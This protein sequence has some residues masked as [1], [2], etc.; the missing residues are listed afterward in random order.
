MR[1]FIALVIVTLLASCADVLG[2]GDF[3]GQ[4]AS[5]DGTTEA[6]A[7]DAAPD[8]GMDEAEAGCVSATADA[9]AGIFVSP[10]GSTDATTCGTETVPCA[11]V[12]TGLDRAHVITGKSIVYV[13]RGTYQESIVLYPG[14]RLEGGWDVLDN[15]TSNSWVQ[16]CSAA[17]SAVVI[18]PQTQNVTVAA[19]DLGGSV[20]V[21]TLTIASKPMAANGESLYGLF[22][23]GASTTLTLTNVN[24]TVAAGGDG[25]T[26]AD[27]PPGDAGGSGC[28]AED[29]A[30]GVVGSL[31]LGADAG[32]FDPDGWE[33]Q[34]GTPG[35]VGTGGAGGATGSTGACSACGSCQNF[36]GCSFKTN[37]TNSCGA[38]GLPGCGGDPGSA[39]NP[40]GGAGSSIGVYV[41]DATV[42]LEG[43]S[44]QVARGGN[45][46][47]GG[48]GGLG[49][50]GG[51]GVV[52]EAGAACSTSCNGS[53][54]PVSGNGPGGAA[55]GSGG[56]GGQGGAGGG[57]AGGCS[58]ATFQGGTG[59][60]LATMTT[61]AHGEAGLGGGPD[62]AA[63]AIGVAG[64]HFP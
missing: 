53:C 49:G 11:S 48:S 58:Y 2:L 7:P 4:D 35:S 17:S 1:R 63:G 42:M 27:G 30:A 62:S 57:G 47:S 22:A 24:V 6:T 60:V 28:A 26:G 13:A 3:H 34:G 64:D 19:V 59:S 31:G 15:G 33:P 56:N 52:G 38:S 18:Q 10:S 46:G 25:T 55:G 12:Q 14:L 20:T 61:L 41:W 16:A 29:A 43:S 23:R 54:N 21:A 36:L 5:S 39:G 51:G 37:G 45:G 40:G 9:T 50:A 44:I 32:V 8:A